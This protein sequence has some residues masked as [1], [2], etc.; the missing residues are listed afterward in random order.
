MEN[1][2]RLHRG[3]NFFIAVFATN[4]FDQ[5]IWQRVYAAKSNA[6]LFK[7][8]VSSFLIV[9]PFLLILGF[10][11]IIAV[12]SGNDK[13]TSTVFFSLLFNSFNELNFLI[14]SS[15]LVLIL[16][17]VISSIDTLINAISSLIII[18]GDKFFRLGP[19]ALR[20][21]S[22]ILIV[23]MSGI[24]FFISSKGYSV[25]FMFLFADLKECCAASF[26]VF[27]GMFKGD[28]SKKLAFWI[29][30]NWT[31]IRYTYFPQSNF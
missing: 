13:D 10:F 18:N 11:G 1:I 5:G 24:V 6:D 16:S 9:F 22:Y 14:I 15:L 19:R 31:Y 2:F 30:N 27:Y 28:L 7:G 12:I 25:L 17:L 21:L 20:Q 4:L 23:L 8:L 3:N 29:C 26:P